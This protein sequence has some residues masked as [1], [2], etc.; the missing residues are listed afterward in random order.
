MPAPLVPLGELGT[1]PFA[2]NSGGGVNKPA[3]VPPAPIVVASP[4]LNWL[5]DPEPYTYAKV[6][7]VRSPGFIPIDGVSGFDREQKWDVKAGKGTTGA[8]TTHVAMEPAKGAITFEL[9]NSD[10]IANWPAFLALF[11]FDTTKGKGQAVSIYHPQ[12][13]S[14]QP[15]ITSVVMTKHTPVKVR[16]DG[17]GVVTVELLEYFPAKAT[18]ATTAQGAKQYASGNGNT[19]GAQEDPAVAKL[20]AQAAALQKQLEGT[21]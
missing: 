11:R 3:N 12:L 15:P 13:A 18:G 9:P 14:V 6:Q 21:A 10:S 1:E 7:G 16:K 19:T 2:S 8:T 20:R 4:L 17:C 5:T